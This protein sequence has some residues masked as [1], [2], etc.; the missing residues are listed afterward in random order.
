MVLEDT[1]QTEG[2]TD[3]SPVSN[4][5]PYADT[6]NVGKRASPFAKYPTNIQ[7]PESGFWYTMFQSDAYKR[8]VGAVLCARMDMAIA[9]INRFPT[10]EETNAFVDQAPTIAGSPIIGGDLGKMAGLGVGVK[11]AQQRSPNASVIHGG[12]RNITRWPLFAKGNAFRMLGFVFI[13]HVAGTILGSFYATSYGQ[14]R[15]SSDYRLAA[16]R[17]DLANQDPADVKRRLNHLMQ[18]RA[19]QSTARNPQQGNMRTTP[20]AETVDDASPTGGSA[21]RYPESSGSYSQQYGTQSY[22]ASPNQAYSPQYDSQQAGN[23]FSSDGNS[24]QQAPNYPAPQ[25]SSGKSF[26]DDDDATPVNPEVARGPPSPPGNAWARIRRDAASQSQ[27]GGAH[28]HERYPARQGQEGGYQA[29]SG[30]N[31]FSYSSSQTDS[32]LVRGQAQKEFD[33]LLERDRQGEDSG[34]GQNSSWRRNW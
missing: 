27:S 1:S 34:N 18:Q 10:Q 30:S 16:Y 5:D 19:R 22:A 24:G 20:A 28:D 3:S 33:S 9:S 15:T 26:W 23:S 12:L 4:V 32:Q 25:E 8:V 7:L 6:G 13:G 14:L 17:R 31:S 11:H 29:N 21:Q 2:F